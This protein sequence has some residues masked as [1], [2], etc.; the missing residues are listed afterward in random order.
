MHSVLNGPPQRHIFVLDPGTATLYEY[1]HFAGCA[2]RVLWHRPK[3]SVEAIGEI[4]K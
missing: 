1:S 3:G 4:Y 2:L